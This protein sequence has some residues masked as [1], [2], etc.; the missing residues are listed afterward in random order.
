MIPTDQAPTLMDR[1]EVVGSDGDSIGKVG[2]V[3]VDNETGALTWVTVKTGWFGANESFVPLDEAALEGSTITVPY[4]KAKVKDAPHHAV[5]AELSVEEEQDLYTYYGVTHAGGSV[6]SDRDSHYDNDNDNDNSEALVS[7]TPRAPTAPS[8]D[9]ADGHIT[10]SEEQLNVGTRTVEAGRARLKKYV[11]TEQQ[12]V[13]VPVSHEEVTL[14]REPIA[15]GEATDAV[16][17]DD[18]V[19]VTLMEDQVVVDKQAVAV[20]K[21]KL[22]TETVTEQQEVTEAVR[23]EQ[24]E[25]TTDGDDA[26]TGYRADT[27]IDND[28]DTSLRERAEGSADQ[29]D[30][31]R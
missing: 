8:T 30:I 29:R 1:G 18:A 31:I 26:T 22:G 28:T 6:D 5:D 27:D 7:E 9:T 21:I 2:Q 16:I 3:Y 19:E 25:M 10:R 23:K 14:V 24:V 12:T 4:D 13:T 17:G 11:V 20:E 15:A